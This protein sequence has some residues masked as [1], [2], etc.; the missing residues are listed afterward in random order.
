MFAIKV[1]L[2]KTY[3]RITKLDITKSIVKINDKETAKINT[4]HLKL[5]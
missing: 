5:E 3:L 4:A 2:K 1:N